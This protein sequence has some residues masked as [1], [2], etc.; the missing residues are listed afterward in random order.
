[1]NYLRVLAFLLLL[2]LINIPAY[3]ITLT[4]GCVNYSNIYQIETNIFLRKVKNVLEEKNWDVNIDTTPKGKYQL[5]TIIYYPAKEHS[6]AENIL[7]I[8]G[9]G[10]LVV[11][12]HSDIHIILGIDAFAKFF[13]KS[14]VTKPLGLLVLNSS[15]IPA[16]ASAITKRLQEGDE[17]KQLPNDPCAQFKNDGVI[18][19]EEKVMK[20]ER[21]QK[22]NFHNP[23]NGGTISD[24]TYLYYPS[25]EDE[26]ADYIEIII[27]A[28]K[29]GKKIAIDGLRDFIIILGTS[30]KDMERI[31]ESI[32]TS[33]FID[34]IKSENKLYL[35]ENNTLIKSYPISYGIHP[36][37]KPHTQGSADCR[38]PEGDNFYICQMQHSATWKYKN[39]EY[40][41]GPWFLRLWA[42]EHTGYGIHGT[43]EIE[44][45]GK[46]ASHGCVRMNNYDVIDLRW[47]VSLGAK[48]RIRQ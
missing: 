29:M 25:G 44:R 18:E 38:T 42:E 40:A 9:L 33:Y 24:T 46:P 8:I 47:R 7:E 3:A 34:I 35:Y 28:G 12:E 21:I 41:Y 13:E 26:L 19:D 2:L 23:A 16:K 43:N 31:N 45:I 22:L 14:I 4:S 48:V 5:N 15:N 27:G 1:M 6:K 36:D 11:K 39:I 10:T 20:R 17:W 37:H 30:L 32:D